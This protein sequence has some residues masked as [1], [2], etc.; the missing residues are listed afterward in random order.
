MS[1]SFP[2][3]FFFFKTIE[4]QIFL[5][6][7]KC[8]HQKN[9]WDTKYGGSLKLIYITNALNEAKELGKKYTMTSAY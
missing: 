2:L 9:I 4:P 8:F 5:I 6:S 7:D 3:S 1:L